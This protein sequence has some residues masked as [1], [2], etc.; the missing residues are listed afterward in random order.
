MPVGIA[1]AVWSG[2]GVTAITLIGWLK[3]GQVLDGPALFGIAL[4]VTGVVVLNGFSR[5][6][7]H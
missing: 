4:I 1:Y 3:F 6:V 2:I 7:A 5:S